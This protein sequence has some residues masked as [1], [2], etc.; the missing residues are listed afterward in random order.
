MKLLISVFLVFSLYGKVIDKIDVIVND[1]P[2]TSYDISQVEKKL[3]ID[4]NQAISY[5]ID[6]SIIKSAI[7][8][9]G[10]YV[11]EFDID[12]AM[13]K[14]AQKNGMSLFNFKTYLLE[15]GQLNDLKAQLKK[16][17]EM[18]KLFE[19]LNIRVTQDDVKNYFKI[20]KDEFK[21][22][23]K[24]E[25]TEYSSKD[26]NALLEVIKNPLM[27]NNNVSIK[28]IT[29]NSDKI[30]PK[31]IQFLSKYKE[32]SFTPIVNMGDKLVSFYIIKKEGD[33]LMD[34]K[35]VEGEIYQKLMQQ[36]QQMAI[37]D[38]VA[39]LKAKANIQILAK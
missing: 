21:V 9:R 12:N 8:D 3:N 11:D 19:A 18:E 29:L 17:L 30:N 39:K 38:F 33:K 27:Q 6:Q 25:V 13:R 35:S 15:K 36:K 24:I 2:I 20:H 37:K 31:L 26:K 7:K 22:A 23:S 28:D 10:I 16:K 14:I 32:G 5:L 34:F 4:K 1:I